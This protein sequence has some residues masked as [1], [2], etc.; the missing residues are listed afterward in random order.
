VI[1]RTLQNKFCFLVFGFLH[2]VQSEFTDE[3]SE[4]PVGTIFTG[5][6][7]TSEDGTHR[8]IRNVVGKLASHIVQKPKNQETIFISR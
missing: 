8:E 1:C 5:Q 7:K 3:V 2:Y 6:M 4:L